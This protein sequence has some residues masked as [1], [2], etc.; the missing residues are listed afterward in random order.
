LQGPVA[1]RRRT[2]QKVGAMLR[3]QNSTSMRRPL[4]HLGKIGW[5]G[6]HAARQRWEK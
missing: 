5:D 4:M 3:E 6:T 2:P 1:T